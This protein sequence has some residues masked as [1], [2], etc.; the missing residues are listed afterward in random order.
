MM[1][2]GLLATAG[3]DM[4]KPFAHWRRR[5]LLLA[6]PSVKL[7]VA[8][9]GVSVNVRGW[10]NY[11]DALGNDLVCERSNTYVPSQVSLDMRGSKTNLAEMRN[12]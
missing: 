2:V 11:K 6:C 1:P 8:I 9:M 5:I 12:T 4:S 7:I 3:A 10:D